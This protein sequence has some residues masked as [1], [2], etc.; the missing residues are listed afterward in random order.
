MFANI[1]LYDVAMGELEMQSL[2]KYLEVSVLVSFTKGMNFKE[3]YVVFRF[4]LR[5]ITLYQGSQKG[6]GL[7]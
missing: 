1:I 2:A 5:S 3:I 7:T 4:L 6:V